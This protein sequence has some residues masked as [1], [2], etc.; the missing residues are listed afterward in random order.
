M[1]SL[2][3]WW[4]RYDAGEDTFKPPVSKGILLMFERLEQTLADE[5]DCNLNRVEIHLKDFTDYRYK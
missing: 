1:E 5:P 2:R 3:K 4:A